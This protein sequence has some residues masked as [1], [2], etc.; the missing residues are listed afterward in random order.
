MEIIGTHFSTD[1]YIYVHY[2]HSSLLYMNVRIYLSMHVFNDS[3]QA[4]INGNG[5]WYSFIY[6]RS[7]YDF[8]LSPSE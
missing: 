5:R 1:I 2:I 8:D 3:Y 7:E 4:L 6:L